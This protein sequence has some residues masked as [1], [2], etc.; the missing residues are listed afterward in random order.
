MMQNRSNSSQT[1]NESSGETPQR[2]FTGIVIQGG[3]ACGSVLLKPSGFPVVDE[4]TA[5]NPEEELHRLHAGILSAV[6][7]LDLMLT[8]M[9]PDSEEYSIFSAH[10]LMLAD[11]VLLKEVETLISTSQRTADFAWIQVLRGYY[12]Q[13]KAAGVGSSM[14]QRSSDIMDV[15][16]RVY[17]EL[18]RESDS[19][20]PR[21]GIL[22]TKELSASDALTL[23]TGVVHGVISERGNETSHSAI[24]VRSK[25]IPVIFGVKKLCDVLKESDWVAM[26]A[27]KGVVQVGYS[28]EL[29]DEIKVK[30]SAFDQR[31]S[32][33][34]S[35]YDDEALFGTHLVQLLANV[36][37]PSEIPDALK[38]GARGVGL[39]R[40]E[41]LYNNRADA[42]DEQEQFEYYHE[43]LT[44]VN[45]QQL[46]IRTADFG[47]DKP[48]A[49]LNQESETN[50]F[51]GLRGIR[52]SLRE[53]SLLKTQIRAL[54]RASNHG[55]IHIL[56]PMIST[57]EEVIRARDMIDVCRS[58]LADEGINTGVFEVGAMIEVPSAALVI[59]NILMHV[60]FISVGTN[61]LIQYVMAADRTQDALREL[62][63][64]YQPA[65]LKLVEQLIKKATEMG[66][67]V[68]ICGEMA[69]QPELTS[70]LLAFGLREFSMT[71]NRI[72]SIKQRISE[73]DPAQVDSILTKFI[74]CKTLS[75]VQQILTNP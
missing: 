10:K 7:A 46:V 30:R 26:D 58:E 64:S 28:A 23:D 55:K 62:T 24:L 11:P 54:L 70:L 61:D 59:E 34:A 40:T 73:L 53:E 69:G 50:P 52:Y 74:N 25:G 19:I 47:G 45:G 32:T 41:F 37:T 42:P 12:E 8:S 60:D 27:E 18:V 38:Y 3:Y 13:W 63:S 5:L 6:R 68:A 21:S 49:Y 72:P 14:E 36:S 51:L 39:F 1:S 2:T 4:V 67:S 57:V 22:V 35:H 75:D 31:S 15:A 9:D 16:L 44:Y 20:I 33:Y 66:K 43:A 65:V 48:I 29:E 17:R 56:F 71:S